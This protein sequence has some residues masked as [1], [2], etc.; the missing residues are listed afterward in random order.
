M[1]KNGKKYKLSKRELE[2]A[3]RLDA[4]RGIV[5]ES[6]RDDGNEDDYNPIVASIPGLDPKKEINKIKARI[7]AEIL[8][9]I[10]E[11]QII[12][13]RLPDKKDELNADIEMLTNTVSKL[14]K[15]FIEANQIADINKLK[16]ILA[17]INILEKQLDPQLKS[18]RIKMAKLRQ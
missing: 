11:F 15:L 1:L 5:S 4:L 9:F 12:S 7:E 14:E 6:S 3:R 10:N 17:K 8:L 16:E 2:I 13:Q 18:A